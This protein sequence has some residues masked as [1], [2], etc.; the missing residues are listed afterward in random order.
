MGSLKLDI[1]T[2]VY[3]DV[4]KIV[5][6][7]LNNNLEDIEEAIWD[8]CSGL[9]DSEYYLIG[10]EAFTKIKKEVEKRLKKERESNG[11][12]TKRYKELTEQFEKILS[13]LAEEFPNTLAYRNWDENVTWDTLCNR[14]YWLL[15]SPNRTS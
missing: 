10:D 2:T 8:Y 9:S 7:C 15:E 1:F 5:E 3:I 14:N 6:N 4:D 11:V 13:D 12:K